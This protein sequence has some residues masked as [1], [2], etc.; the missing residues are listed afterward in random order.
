MAA[1]YAQVDPGF[2]PGI[3]FVSRPDVD[4]WEGLAAWKPRPD[5]RR[6]RQFNFTY[7]PTYITD[8]QGV[9]Q[10][11][12]NFLLF[13]TSFESG[14]TAGLYYD[15]QFEHLPEEGFNIF[16]DPAGDRA[17]DI[18]IPAGSYSFASTGL[19]LNTFQGRRISSTS[20]FVVGT[21]YDG[22]K[23]S[24]AQGLTVNFSPHFSVSTQYDYNHVLLP[25]GNFD[26]NLW[27]TRFN[28][29]VSPTLF[30]SALVQANDITD[31]L[32]LNLR[33]DWIHHPGA[34]LFFVYNESSN[35]RR[36]LGEPASNGRDATFKLT[37][38]FT[39]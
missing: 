15:P 26:T 3:G 31:D 21:F 12:E 4:L 28:V 16:P 32:D 13:E 18:V 24:I 8:R 5:S 20:T 9:L 29:A 34:D 19:Y 37:Y 22:R 11:R 33:V 38:L 39:F 1:R 7:N 36:R 30:G 27:I 17:K 25:E 10:S 6:V 14:D 23:T 35:L 2:D